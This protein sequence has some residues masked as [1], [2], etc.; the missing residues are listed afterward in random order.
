VLEAHHLPGQA[1]ELAHGAQRDQRADRLVLLR[2][3]QFTADAR[4]QVDQAVAGLAGDALALSQGH[5]DGGAAV[6]AVE[7]PAFLV[8]G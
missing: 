1:F 6:R 4:T 7:L 5:L 3:A 2:V 8:L